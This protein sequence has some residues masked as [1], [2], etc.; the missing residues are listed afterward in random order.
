MKRPWAIA[1]AESLMLLPCLE[2]CAQSLRDLMQGWRGHERSLARMA[3][4]R[5]RSDE[6]AGRE[7]LATLAAEAGDVQS[8]LHSNTADARDFKAMFGSFAATAQA[9]AHDLGD[10]RAFRVRL[11]EIHASCAGCHGKYKE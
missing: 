8:Q 6:L 2:A 5:T 1:L 3:S 10:Y 11:G 4:S 9:T 7:M